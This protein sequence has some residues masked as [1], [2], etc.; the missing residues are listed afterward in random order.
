[1]N[2]RTTLVV[3]TAFTLTALLTGCMGENDEDCESR[4]QLPAT[5]V[6]AMVDGKGGGSGGGGSRSGSS[7]SRSGG[8]KGPSSTSKGKTGG[9]KGGKVKLGDGCDD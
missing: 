3:A 9:G 4:G 1:M 8:S 5:P 2:K 7:S 6:A